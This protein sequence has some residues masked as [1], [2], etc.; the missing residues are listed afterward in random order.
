MQFST[1]LLALVATLATANPVARQLN[2]VKGAV[3]SIASALTKLDTAVVAVSPS[4]EPKATTA[5]LNGKSEAVLAAIKAG[6]TSIHDAKVLSL[7]DAIGLT[8]ASTALSIAANTTVY[9]L[10]AKKPIFD[11]V[12][13]SPV[14]LKQLQDQLVATSAF[15]TELVSKLPPAVASIGKTQAKVATDAIQHGI[16]VFGAKAKREVEVEA[17]A[18]TE[19]EVE[20]APEEEGE[21]EGEQEEAEA[22]AD[23]TN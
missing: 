8:Q 2:V 10:I 17:E 22:A 7:G 11:K 6:T 3:E 15:S 5:D 18:E 21:A 13:Q 23:P 14:V 20:G 4:S 19:A 12:G 1:V 16:D 9:D